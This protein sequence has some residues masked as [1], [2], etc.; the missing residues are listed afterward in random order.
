MTSFSP[1]EIEK[2]I[3]E[4]VTEVERLVSGIYSDVKSQGFNSGVP[5]EFPVSVEVFQTERGLLFYFEPSDFFSFKIIKTRKKKVRWGFFELSAHFNHWK[6]K[7][8]EK[9]RFDIRR[10]YYLPEDYESMREEDANRSGEFEAQY[11]QD[12]T[13]EVEYYVDYLRESKTIIGETIEK[14][15]F[16]CYHLLHIIQKYTAR[17]DLYIKSG[18]WVCFET[19]HIVMNE[20]ETSIF[21]MLHGKYQSSLS[22][23]RKIFEILCR[24]IYLDYMLKD[25]DSYENMKNTWFDGN[26]FPILFPPMIIELINDSEINI[27]KKY[28]QKNI[29]EDELNIRTKIIDIYKELSKYVHFVTRNDMNNLSLLFSQYDAVD[30]NNYYERFIEVINITDILFILKNPTIINEINKHDFPNFDLKNMEALLSLFARTT[31]S[32]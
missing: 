26:N 3:R 13:M 18:S 27:L 20:I 22:S 4:Y 31:N 8:Y 32:L 21:L 5:L 7:G 24:A 23:L 16:E 19:Y 6:D 30:M 12:I 15:I 14:N 29:Y 10:L 1:N 9:A 11:V 17:M 28:F 2:Y 25:D